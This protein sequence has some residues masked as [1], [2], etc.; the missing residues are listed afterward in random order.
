MTAQI[1]WRRFVEIVKD[2]KQHT[3]T[4]AR[5]IKGVRNTHKYNRNA[6]TAKNESQQQHRDDDS[7]EWR[8][9]VCESAPASSP[10]RA[11]K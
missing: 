2:I 8:L 5:I 9:Q 10:A 1:Q 7:G 6:C 3:H 11:Q 4:R